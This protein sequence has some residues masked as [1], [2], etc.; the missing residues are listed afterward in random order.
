MGAWAPNER[1]DGG[2]GFDSVYLTGD[3][4][5][6]FGAN[7]FRSIE[8]IALSGAFNYKLT[9]HDGTVAAGNILQIQAFSLDAAHKASINGAAELDGTF[10]MSGGAGRDALT[11]GAGA[12]TL[13]GNDGADTLVGGDGEDELVGGVGHDELTGGSGQDVFSFDDGESPFANPDLI[14]D[15][16]LSDVVSLSNID[17]NSTLAFDQLFTLVASFGGNAGELVVD[18]DS[19]TNITSFL[20][21]T[22]GDSAADGVIEAVGNK[23]AFVQFEL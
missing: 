13:R 10:H 4:K 3:Y 11:G 12:D 19:G 18:Y 20:M 16:Q 9:T 6:K 5:E 8:A 23:S 14:L 15:L 21:D 22:D 2:S 1:I 17:A 7:S